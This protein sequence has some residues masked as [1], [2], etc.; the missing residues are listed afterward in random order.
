MWYY[1]YMQLI[2]KQ[3]RKDTPTRLDPDAELKDMTVTAKFFSP[4][5]AWS[6]YLIELDKDNNF[7][8]GIV[9]SEFCPNGE[10][11]SFSIKELEELDAPFGLA[12]ERDIHFEKVN[13]LELF[14]SLQ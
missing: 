4:W 10:I 9:T 11:G 1:I 3:I 8:Y 2:T 6:W 14:N 5:G 12:V 7:A 13:A